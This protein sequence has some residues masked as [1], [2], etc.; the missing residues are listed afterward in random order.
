MI[1]IEPVVRT[2]LVEVVGDD[3]A[4]L[5]IAS[6]KLVS[7]GFL[8]SFAMIELAARLEDCLNLTI[9]AD[10]LNENDFTSL[11]S[12]VRLCRDLCGITGHA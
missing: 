3:R 7:D 11:A 6:T 8:D 5:A 10:R 4:N 9:P 2:L 12:L 1:D